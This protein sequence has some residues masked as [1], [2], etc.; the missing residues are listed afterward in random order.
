L[1][2]SEADRRAISTMAA[3]STR[4]KLHRRSVEG[5]VHGGQVAAMLG[6]LSGAMPE[7]FILVW[8]RAS[9]HRGK[10]VRE[11]L[12]SHPKLCVEPLP[13]YAPELNPEEYAHGNIKVHLLNSAPKDRAE[14]RR[15][16][17]RG[18]ARLRRR[19]DLLLGCFRKAGLA[20]NQFW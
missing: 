2:R 20:V 14:M 18:F 4:G 1:R 12:R 17:K 7:G 19:P 11:F 10:P 5:S 16:L 3:L 13:A 6:R 8:D 9:I 15:G